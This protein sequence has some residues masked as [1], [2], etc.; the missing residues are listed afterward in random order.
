MLKKLGEILKITKSYQGLYIYQE[1]ISFRSNQDSYRQIHG[2]ESREKGILV[3][4]TPE[5]NLQPLL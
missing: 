2:W 4:R 3:K 1:L 5:Q